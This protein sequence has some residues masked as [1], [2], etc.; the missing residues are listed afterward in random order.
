MLLTG[1]VRDGDA[2]AGMTKAQV[3][4]AMRTAPDQ[5]TTFNGQEAWVYFH[6]TYSSPHRS[7]DDAGVRVTPGAPVAGE[8]PLG[9][10]SGFDHPHTGGGASAEA[11]NSGSY[12]ASDKKTGMRT[13]ILFVGDHATHAEVTR[14]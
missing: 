1:K 7:R 9:A 13:T 5:F 4:V 3:R 11:S 14:D 6:G 10:G 8:D 12:G 2:I